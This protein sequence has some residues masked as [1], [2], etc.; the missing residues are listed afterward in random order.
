MRR[1]GRDRRSGETRKNMDRENRRGD[2]E[3]QGRG[4][5]GE[6]SETGGKGKGRRVARCLLINESFFSW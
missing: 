5:K 4:E 1:D 3:T 6:T 2:T